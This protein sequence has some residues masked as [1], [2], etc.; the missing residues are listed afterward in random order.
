MSRRDILGGLDDVSDRR[1]D[2]RERHDAMG[3]RSCMLVGPLG[4]LALPISAL[5]CCAMWF[6]AIY[7]VYRW[8]WTLPLWI[9]IYIYTGPWTYAFG[10]AG[11][12]NKVKKRTT[13]LLYLIFN[14]PFQRL[15]K[16]ASGDV[17]GKRKRD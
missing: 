2:I 13:A 16:T 9:L 5:L 10:A 6:G 14:V 15:R 4:C 17:S 1:P 11:S 8:P 3:N 7:C 12:H